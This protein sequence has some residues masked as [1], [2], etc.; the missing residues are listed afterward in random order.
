EA[1]AVRDADAI[2]DRVAQDERA[3]RELRGRLRTE[4]L[5][6]IPPDAHASE[7]LDRGE[8]LIAVRDAVVVTL[9]PAPAE[10]PPRVVRLYVTT[11]RIILAD[12]TPQ[13]IP[14]DQIDELSLAAE[15]ILLTLV[16][17]EGICLDAGPPR[18]LR[19][20]IAAARAGI[21]T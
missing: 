15:Q 20:Q 19:V 2:L 13:T 9:H 10:A 3:A 5:T 1:I 21:R 18:L 17:G 11:A 4:P 12:D 16:N 6:T 14:L 7:L 8:G